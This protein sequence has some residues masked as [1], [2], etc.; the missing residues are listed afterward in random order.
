MRRIRILQGSFW[1]GDLAVPGGIPWTVIDATSAV[2]SGV[3]GR[4]APSVLCADAAADR[5]VGLE[6]WPYQFLG[7]CWRCCAVGDA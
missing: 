6:R 4:Q 1:P 5:A 2:P 7:A 3:H